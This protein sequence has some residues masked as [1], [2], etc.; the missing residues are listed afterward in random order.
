MGGETVEVSGQG[1]FI[2]NRKN[3]MFMH[4]AISSAIHI[5]K[6]YRNTRIK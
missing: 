1:P 5:K 4:Q 2:G 6:E 3:K